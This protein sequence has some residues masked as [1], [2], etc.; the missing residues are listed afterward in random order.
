M[1]IGYEE[2]THVFSNISLILP[3]KSSKKLEH[4]ME[5]IYT[6]FMND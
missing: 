2:T 4:N 1:E 3:M 6:D 5:N